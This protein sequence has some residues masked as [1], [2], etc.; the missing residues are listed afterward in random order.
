MVAFILVLAWAAAGAAQQVDSKAE[1]EMLK[2]LNLERARQG[3][4][5]LKLDPKLQEAARQH[6]Q[7]MAAKRQ[8][9]HEIGDEPAFSRRLESAG[10]QFSSAGEN[11]VLNQSAESANQALMQSPPHRAN[12]LSTKFNS[13]GIGVVRA[14]EDLWVTEDF[15][16][17]YEKITEQQARDRVFAAFQ[18]ARREAKAPAVKL[19]KEPR[20]QTIAC[21]MAHDG[22]LATRDVLALPN[23]HTAVAYTE[24]DISALPSSARKLAGDFAVGRIAI[25]ACFASSTKYPSGMYWVVIA[26][27]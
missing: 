13:V 20:L 9:A 24:S 27:Y 25:G 17:E 15:A 18:D 6:S 4:M 5:S 3:L 26:G 14:G 2:L 16:R 23:V 1:Q 22:Q 10:A 11:V 21:R 19:V 7:L 12:I 8:L